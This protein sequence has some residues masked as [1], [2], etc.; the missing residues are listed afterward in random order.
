MHIHPQGWPAPTTA[1]KLLGA[2]EETNWNCNCQE[3]NVGQEMRKYSKQTGSRNVTNV[4]SQTVST[5]GDLGRRG[6]SRR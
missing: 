3:A 6:F 1:T 4:A 5:R 2:P